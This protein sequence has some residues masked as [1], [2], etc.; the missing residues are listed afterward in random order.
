MFPFLKSVHFL[1]QSRFLLPEG[2]AMFTVSF[3]FVSLSGRLLDCGF[4]TESFALRP[5]SVAQHPKHSVEGQPKRE[6][7]RQTWWNPNA[8][9]NVARA[10]K[11]ACPKMPTASHGWK[12]HT[13]CRLGL[14]GIS[15][16]ARCCRQGGLEPLRVSMPPCR[17]SRREGGATP[18]SGT[19]PQPFVKGCGRA[20]VL[21]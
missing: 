2:D 18:A 21:F 7:A 12:T 3:I 1:G 5:V 13:S 9:Q 16:R 14:A 19:V 10:C 4:F 8:A 15:T 17:L 20:A 6:H 11:P